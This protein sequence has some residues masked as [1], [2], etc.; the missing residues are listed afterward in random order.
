MG[1]GTVAEGLPVTKGRPRFHPERSSIA[2]MADRAVLRR[3]GGVLLALAPTL[4][5]VAQLGRIHPDEV[6]QYL[7]PAYARVHGYG[8]LAWEWREGLRN[9]AYPGLLAL[10]LRLSTALGIAHPVAYRAVLAMPQLLLHAAALLAV[11][12]FAGRRTPKGA[13]LATALV[14]LQGLAWVYA[15]RTLGESL[16]VAFLW[17]ALER[18]DRPEAPR[19][20]D[21]FGG[22][23]LGLTVV[24]RYGSA[25]A[26]AG[27]L[28][29]L[30]M[31]RA[32]GR[33][34]ACVA[35]GSVAALA[36]G[37]LDWATWGAPFH[38]LL[39]YARFNVLS[40]A[41]AQRFGASGPGYYA[42]P[43]VLATPLWV[44]VAIATGRRPLL[45]SAA[46]PLCAAAVYALAI[47]AAPHKEE[48]FLYPLVQLLAF[49][50]APGFAAGLMR[51]PER[52]R[53]VGSVAAVGA[54]ALTFIAA[55]DV[56]G[57]QFRAIVRA[58][59]PAEVKGLLIVNEGLWGAGGYFYVGKRIPWM[60]CDWPRDVAF[61]RA[62]GDPR[63]NRVVTFEDRA[64]G[65]LEAAGFR[66]V[67]RI[68][69][70]TIFAR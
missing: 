44:W 29:Y 55:P 10:L 31:R 17:I 27:V 28:G 12:R 9:W 3:C 61:R 8:V 58:A 60:T 53:F 45:R 5:A 1:A 70:E 56:R 35:G 48:R 15:G 7:E 26:V 68:G 11:H 21:A 64:R 42:L 37:G 62:M 50:A 57:D 20:N 40:G 33:L 30:A 25:A 13:A 4:L 51:A 69:R 6:Y 2:R 43:F 46:L 36:L 38:S 65:E 34:F 41:A 63:I 22:F 24:V 54:S 47:V 23:L 14:G 67:E 18:L 49:A 16:S 32:W 39:A 52:L 19:W 66:S 59:R